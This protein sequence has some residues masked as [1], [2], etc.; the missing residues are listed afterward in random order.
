MFI[1][2]SGAGAAVRRGAAGA[3]RLGSGT[4]NDSL[5]TMLNG[6]YLGNYNTFWCEEK[7]TCVLLF[8]DLEN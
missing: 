1:I 2:G 4:T 5:P 8:V 6:I 7:V 3:G